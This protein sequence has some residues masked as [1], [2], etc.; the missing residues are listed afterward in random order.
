MI[1]DEVDTGIGGAI[2]EV[3]GQKLR[4]LGT[5]RQ[6]LC[7]THLPQVAAQG[8]AH[9]RVSKHSDEQSTRTQIEVLDVQ[10]R[11]DELARMLGGVEITRETRAHAKQMLERAQNS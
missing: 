10:G 11:R 5:Q 7:V 6:V 2:A 3:V 8:H 1:F 9:L 4:T